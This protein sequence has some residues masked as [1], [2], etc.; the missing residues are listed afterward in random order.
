MDSKFPPVL[1]RQYTSVVTKDCLHNRKQWLAWRLAEID[2]D[3]SDGCVF[4]VESWFIIRCDSSPGFCVSLTTCPHTLMLSED[5]WNWRTHTESWFALLAPFQISYLTELNFKTWL[6]W[7]GVRLR[8][9]RGVDAE[10]VH[11]FSVSLKNLMSRRV[12]IELC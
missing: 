6:V 8:S 4:L 1:K 12:S 5:L 9:G 7:F 3:W 2:P 10:L 11:Q